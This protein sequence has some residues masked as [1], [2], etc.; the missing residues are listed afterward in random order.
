MT[1]RKRLTIWYAALLT[2]IIIIFGTITFVVM[3]LTMVTTI[4]SSLRETASLVARNSRLALAPDFGAGSNVILELAKLDVFRASNVYVQAWRIQDGDLHFVD[5][6]ANLGP[7]DQPLDADALNS[8]SDE[9]SFSN[10]TIEGVP[11]RV[12]TSPIV[13]QGDTVVG[14]IQVAADLDTVN[15][16]TELLLVVMLVSSGTAII[17]AGA[18]SLWFSH[19]ALKPI[20]DIAAAASQI[21]DAEDLSIRLGWNGPQDELGR[22]ISVF[23]QMMERLEHLFQVQRRFVADISHELRTP[24]TTIRGNLDLIERYGL[25]EYEMEAMKSETERMSRLISDL[26]MLARADYGGIEI[27]LFPIDLDTIVLD[28]FEQAKVLV[29]ERDLKIKMERFE[30]VRINGNPD[31]LKQMLLNLV[32]N[33]IKYT[34]D[35]GEI[36]F[37]LKNLGLW[38][39]ITVSDTGAGIGEEHLSHIFDRFYQSDPARTHDG[40]GFGLGLSIAKWIVDEHKGTISV[41]SK[42]GAGTT[43]TVTLPTP[44]QVVEQHHHNTSI[45]TQATR[46]RIPVISRHEQPNSHHHSDK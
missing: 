33:A 32:T 40:G 28:V 5:K 18:L 19:R 15:R 31:R 8:T 16:A 4:D 1:I 43:F 34:E 10:V 41:D 23:N 29:R 20:D 22:L 24:I 37:S 30:P 38:A 6:S 13:V 46:P 39:V 14:H 7:I 44:L 26:L 17:G 21:V 42:L 11:L 36:S 9:P 12:H 45:H 2:L 25:H 27:E 3:R 35:G